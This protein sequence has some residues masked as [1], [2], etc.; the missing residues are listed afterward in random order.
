[1]ALWAIKNTVSLRIQKSA[2]LALIRGNCRRKRQTNI[3]VD[4][5]SIPKRRKK[6]TG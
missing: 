3:P 1:M 4:D 2:A 5:A 6:S